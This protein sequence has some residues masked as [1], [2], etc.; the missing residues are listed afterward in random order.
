M[1]D[2]ADGTAE[3]RLGDVVAVPHSVGE[4]RRPSKVGC[5]RRHTQTHVLTA[6]TE[7]KQLAREVHHATQ[8]D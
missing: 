5:S 7:G 1:V 6:A 8:V 3:A 2:I 4:R